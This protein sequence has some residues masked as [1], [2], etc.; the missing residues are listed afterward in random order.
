M[1]VTGECYTLLYVCNATHKRIEMRVR[2]A[3][4]LNNNMSCGDATKAHKALGFDKCD[5]GMLTHTLEENGQKKSERKTF[6]RNLNI[7]I[8]SIEK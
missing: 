1:V 7:K 3:L 8:Q 4:N 6:V 5:C 2:I